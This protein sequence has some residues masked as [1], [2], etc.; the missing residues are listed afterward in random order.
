MIRLPG[1]TTVERAPA[2]A[3]ARSRATPT[4]RYGNGVRRR[5]LV[6]AGIVALV[7]ILFNGFVTWLGKE[8]WTMLPI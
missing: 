4:T 1:S 6:G 5:L 2:I 7:A 3:F 8:N